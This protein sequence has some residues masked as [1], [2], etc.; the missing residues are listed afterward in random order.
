MI[1]FS[2]QRSTRFPRSKTLL[3]CGIAISSFLALGLH[4]Q[5]K[6]E[7]FRGTWQIDTPEKGGLIIIVKSQGRASYFWGE[8]TDRTVYTGIWTSDGE[9]A[10]LTWGDNSQHR[11]EGNS[12][13]FAITYIDAGGR[14]HYVT[15]AQ[16]VPAEILGQWAKPPTKASKV[17]SELDQAKERHC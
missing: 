5:S 9:I 2:M 7:L 12:L 10:T 14:E 6:D 4:A 16:Q 17:A 11:I 3:F 1:I 15:K 8:N 13:G